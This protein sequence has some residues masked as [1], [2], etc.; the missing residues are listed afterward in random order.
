MS[1]RKKAAGMLYA[2]L[3]AYNM[4]VNNALGPCIKNEEKEG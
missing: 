3:C 2:K 1:I 4:L